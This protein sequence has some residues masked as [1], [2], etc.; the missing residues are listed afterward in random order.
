MTPTHAVKRGKRY[1]YYISRPLTTGT[2]Q[3]APAGQRIPA[4][5]IE[6]LVVNRLHAAI[7]DEAMILDAIQPHIDDATEL[8]RLLKCANSL[9]HGWSQLEAPQVRALLRAL[10]TRIDVLPKKVDI[11][12]IPSRVPEVLLKDSPELPPASTHAGKTKLLTLSVPAELKRAGMGM[13]MII[14]ARTAQGQ[15]TRPD[16]SLVK[17]I[18]KAH[19][20]NNK[21]VN[22][23]GTSLAAV[24]RHE[25]LT[26]SY[27]TRLLRLSFLSPDIT[28]AILDGRQPPDLTAAR[29]IRA[30]R[31]PL[32]WDQ[33]KAVLGFA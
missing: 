12:L 16:S 9:S 23:G 13:K 6:H 8:K 30:S 29:L 15:K 24:A 2:K 5:D 18:I 19:T 22:S 27:V 4:G 31:L 20:L 25:G 1:R 33:Q 3:N 17:L 21:V 28:R 14:D 10:I 7:S 11:H 32:V 26:G